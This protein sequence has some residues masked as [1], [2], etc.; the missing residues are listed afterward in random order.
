MD[1]S[2]VEAIN[3]Q[4][5]A[6]DVEEEEFDGCLWLMVNYFCSCLESNAGTH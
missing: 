4:Q 2:F 1:S 6:V 5:R 3:R